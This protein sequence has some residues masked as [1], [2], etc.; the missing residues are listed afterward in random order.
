MVSD[1]F[2][3]LILF[4]TILWMN[5]VYNSFKS[6][7]LFNLKG[8]ENHSL[9]QVQGMALLGHDELQSSECS[10]REDQDVGGQYSNDGER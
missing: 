6:T 4:L 1:P 8:L 7:T 5:H 10:D 3:L 9:R 2:Q